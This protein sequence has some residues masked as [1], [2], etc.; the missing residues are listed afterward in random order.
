MWAVCPERDS[1]S[2]FCTLEGYV[3]QSGARH[4]LRGH[5]RATALAS[6]P[7]DK[8]S[9]RLRIRFV[10]DRLPQTSFGDERFGRCSQS[11]CE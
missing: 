5:R 10:A 1:T 9:L 2:G 8:V 4:T 6:S 7:S 3:V 11:A